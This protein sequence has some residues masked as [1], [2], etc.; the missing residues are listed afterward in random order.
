MW[1]CRC[2]TFLLKVSKTIYVMLSSALCAWRSDDNLVG[3]KWTLKLL[4]VILQ[5]YS[6]YYIIICYIVLYYTLLFIVLCYLMYFSAV[7]LSALL[8]RDVTSSSSSSNSSHAKAVRYG[9]WSLIARVHS[10]F[11]F[12]LF[13]FLIHFFIVDTDACFK[14]QLL[15]SNFSIFYLLDIYPYS[16]NAISNYHLASYYH[17]F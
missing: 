2:N 15:N 6:Y 5:I 4:V 3:M 11:Q 12:D 8:S 9:F 10:I 13:M 7:Q 14:Q 17:I 1:V 16:P